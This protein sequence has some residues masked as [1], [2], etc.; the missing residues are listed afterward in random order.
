METQTI[1]VSAIRIEITMPRK[2]LRL[3]PSGARPS[4]FAGD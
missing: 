2:H 4:L 1:I 3:L